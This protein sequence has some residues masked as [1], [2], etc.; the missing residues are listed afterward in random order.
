MQTVNDVL[1]IKTRTITNHRNFLDTKVM[2]FDEWCKELSQK[3]IKF[4]M[5]LETL[6][7]RDVFFEFELGRFFDS[8]RDTDYTAEKLSTWYGNKNKSISLVKFYAIDEK[9]VSNGR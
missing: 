9:I 4:D 7:K 5:C 3:L 1:E 6:K 8:G 2:T